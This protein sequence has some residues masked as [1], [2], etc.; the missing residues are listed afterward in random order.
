MAPLESYR[1]S[2][3]VQKIS[4]ITLTLALSCSG[5]QF[6]YI[7]YAASHQYRLIRDSV[8]VEDALQ[9]D[10]IESGHK[11]RLRLVATIK[12][13]GEKELGLK[14]TL[15]YQTVY[16][17]SDQPTIYILSASPKDS[18]IMSSWWFPIVGDMPY[19]GFFD[20]EGAR[21]EKD[22]LVKKGL[23]VNIG[24]A[25]AYSTLGWFKDPVTL[26]LLE[27]S[28]VE[29]TET[30]LHEMTHNTMYIKGQGEFNEGLA[31]LVG[32][33]GALSFMRK[34]YGDTH[35]FTIEAENNLVD[36]RLFSS[37]L[38]SLLEKLDLLYKSDIT[39]Q[40]KLVEREK[41]FKKSLKEFAD[42]QVNFKTDR[43][44]GFGESGLNNAYLMSIGLYN[45]H[46]KLFEEAMMEDGNSVE[47]MLNHL[48]KMA[49]EGSDMLEGM[50]GL[51]SFHEDSGLQRNSSAD[52]LLR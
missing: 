35:P 6:R 24:V 37:F 48:Q 3:L 32:K 9:G 29:L 38:A 30:I 14:K 31:N 16:L 25:E 13:F 4:I 51:S 15:N 10:L 17:K 11:T 8:K 42:I 1:I 41:I 52:L 19:L 7:L 36:E 49:D 23:D 43:F 18:L 22:R 12:D 2:A 40:E 33:V 50:K 27:R 39:Y 45:R 21:K 20:L 26:N 28:T 5:C 47:N 44:K 46:F 34:T